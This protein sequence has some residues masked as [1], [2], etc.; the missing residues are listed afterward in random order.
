V[1]K[2]VNYIIQG[3]FLSALIIFSIVLISRLL[4]VKPYNTSDVN[5]IDQSTQGIPDTSI[6][7]SVALGKRLFMRNCAACHNLFKNM[8]G[9][10]LVGFT[11][12]GPWAERKNVYEWIRNPSAFMEKNEYARDLKKAFGSMMSAFPGLSNQEIDAICDYINQARKIQF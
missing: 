2:Q 1:N 10:G 11:E 6:N 12:R 8:T 9:P 3:F 4:S 5:R 7:P